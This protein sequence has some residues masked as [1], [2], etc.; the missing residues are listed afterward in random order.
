MTRL[1]LGPEMLAEA[2][3]RNLTRNQVEECIKDLYDTLEVRVGR[4]LSR[5]ATALQL[6]QFEKIID[7]EGDDGPEGAIWLRKNL[8]DYRE[9]VVEELGLILDRL[10]AAAAAHHIKRDMTPGGR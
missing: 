10:K 9:V 4:S 3:Y 7:R 5:K 1:S 6:A 2:G 8:P